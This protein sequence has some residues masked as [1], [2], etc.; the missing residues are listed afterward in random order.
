M[1]TEGS[2]VV[3]LTGQERRD[4]S[5]RPVWSP[6][7]AGSASSRRATA[8]G[9]STW[10]DRTARRRKPTRGNAEDGDLPARSPGDQ[11]IAFRRSLGIPAGVCVVPAEGRKVRFATAG[12]WA[13]WLLVGDR[14]A[15]SQLDSLWAVSVGGSGQPMGPVLRI[16][17]EAGVYDRYPSWWPDGA[18]LAFERD[19]LGA[20]G[21]Q[22]H[23][24][25]VNA[26][27]AHLRDLGQGRLPA[28]WGAGWA[29]FPQR[30][31]S[32]ARGSGIGRGTPNWT[33]SM[34]GGCP[35]GRLGIRAEAGA[36][37]RARPRAA[38]VCGAVLDPSS[39]R[40]APAVDV[41]GA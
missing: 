11:W 26:S 32:L 23:I 7:G 41:V 3:Q 17:C 27:G 30:R 38:R 33:P 40:A 14:I 18:A 37:R 28:W 10:C 8:M 9:G 19:R 34:A 4:E 29:S 25:T 2:G 21:Y 31:E 13:W 39:T 12:H 16:T 20:K 35:H 22:R 1:G 36:V 15:Y 5:S 24:M 6:G